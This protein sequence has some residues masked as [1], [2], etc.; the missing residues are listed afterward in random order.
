MLSS[1]LQSEVSPRVC[2]Q[3]V[4]SSRAKVGVRWRAVATHDDGLRSG[5]LRA[6]HARLA[7]T[8]EPER[9]E[10]RWSHA[11]LWHWRT[12]HSHPFYHADIML[13]RLNTSF[14]GSGTRA[15]QPVGGGR[16]SWEA[17]TM[18]PAASERRGPTG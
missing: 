12:R 9:E 18:R 11:R 15:R 8:G 5:P 1:M 3:A 14:V 4:G 17:L 13:S 6:R 2:V 16:C 7:Q 10:E